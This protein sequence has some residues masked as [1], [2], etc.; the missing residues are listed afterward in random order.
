[1]QE[2]SF[3]LQSAYMLVKHNSNLCGQKFPDYPGSEL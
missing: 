2:E 3:C 1:V